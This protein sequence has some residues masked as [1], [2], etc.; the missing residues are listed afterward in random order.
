MKVIHT[1]IEFS[2]SWEER[3]RLIGQGLIIPEALDRA[4][5]KRQVEFLAGRKCAA[6]GISQLTG[7]YF[8]ETLP[9]NEDRSPQWPPSLIGSI[10]HTQGYAG[11]LV[12]FRQEFAGLGL[13]A[14]RLIE[15]DSKGMAKYICCPQELDKLLE[16][17]IPLDRRQTLTLVFSA[18][19]SLFK[20]IFPLVKT[21]FGF[22][23]AKLTQILEDRTSG[24]FSGTL[25]LVNAVGCFPKGFQF[26]T[27]FQF[28]EDLCLTKTMLPSKVY[29]KFLMI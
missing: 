26:E 18:K 13:D 28:R 17:G 21:F 25:E 2:V 15:N 24:Q 1:E 19:E 14:E 4:V 27:A 11:A 10:T 7:Q 22:H 9:I 3:E 6:N 5:L 23:E 8:G 12:G 16:T 20:C 29:E